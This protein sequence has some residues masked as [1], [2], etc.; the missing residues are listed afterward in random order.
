MAAKDEALKRAIEMEVEGKR[1]YEGAAQKANS[2]LAKGIFEALA[3][4]EDLH[5]RRIREIYE[6]LK[7][8]G[9]Q[10]WVRTVGDPSRLRK[11]FDGALGEEAEASEGDLEALRFALGREEEAF[12]Y[13]EELAQGATDPAERRFWLALSWEERGHYLQIMDSIEY[14]TDPE[15]WL[16]RA[17]RWGLGG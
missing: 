1:F 3:R 17:E 6:G 11:V 2:A 7:A 15:G 4:E 8:G 13:Y 9:F 14:L 5:M 16:R 12:K 10:G